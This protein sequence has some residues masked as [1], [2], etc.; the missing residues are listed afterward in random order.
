VILSSCRASSPCR[1]HS[2]DEERQYRTSQ[3]LRK[4]IGTIQIESPGMGVIITGEYFAWNGGLGVSRSIEMLIAS[5]FRCV[6]NLG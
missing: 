2:P 4:P 5:L 1:V 3:A 6:L